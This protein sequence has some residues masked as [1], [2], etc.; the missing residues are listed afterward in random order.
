MNEEG[1][2]GDYPS[3]GNLNK[4]FAGYKSNAEINIADR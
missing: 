2:K 1:K 3:S 4:I